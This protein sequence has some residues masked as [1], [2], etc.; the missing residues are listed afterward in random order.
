MLESQ[1]QI[2]Q[3]MT[4]KNVYSMTFY[5]LVAF[6]SLGSTDRMLNNYS[7][8]RPERKTKSSTPPFPSPPHTFEGSDAQRV[9]VCP[10]A[11]AIRETER[12]VSEFS[13]LIRLR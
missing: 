11:D 4:V 8:K 1:Q 6:G 12:T 10:A 3:D 2:F 13:I 9:C 5:M 7:T